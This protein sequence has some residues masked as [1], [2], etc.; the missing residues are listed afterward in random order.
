ML[1]L[2]AEL[3][4]RAAFRFAEQSVEMA[5]G[6]EAAGEAYLRHRLPRGEQHTCRYAQAVINQVAVR[7]A[8]GLVAEEARERLGGHVRYIRHLLKTYIVHVMRRYLL[9]DQFDAFILVAVARIYKR[10]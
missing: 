5:Q 10:R 6:V 3:R 1:K 2:F 4:R 9:L 8:A 7:R